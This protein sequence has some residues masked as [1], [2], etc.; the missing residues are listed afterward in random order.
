MP[1]AAQAKKAPAKKSVPAPRPTNVP[2]PAKKAVPRP[3]SA[4]FFELSRGGTHITFT[5]SD[6][7]GKP[8]IH[9]DDGKRQLTFIGDQIERS[10]AS[11]GSILTVDLEVVADGD[12]KALTL[13]IPRVNLPDGEPVKVKTVVIYTKIRGSLAGPGLVQGQVQS[14]AAQTFRGTASFIFT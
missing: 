5:A 2:A 6:I 7:S 3:R 11:I 10:K 1:K 4:N 14:Y 12:T 8:Q 9:Y 13:L